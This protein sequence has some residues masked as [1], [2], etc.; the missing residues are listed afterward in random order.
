MSDS[1][2]NQIPIMFAIVVGKT[3]YKGEWPYYITTLIDRNLMPPPE[4]PPRRPRLPEDVRQYSFKLDA[5][6][7]P[8]RTTVD[9]DLM[10]EDT[11]DWLVLDTPPHHA[12]DRELTLQSDKQAT[13]SFTI[14]LLEAKN[15]ATGLDNLRARKSLMRLL[16]N[17][18]HGLDRPPV[19]EESPEVLARRKLQHEVKEIRESNSPKAD[20]IVLSKIRENYTLELG[21]SLGGDWFEHAMM[22]E[23]FWLL[24][25]DRVLELDTE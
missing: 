9:G 6:K 18:L 11:G 24:V 15:G 7:G 17:K 16:R 5:T 22:D 20:M 10:E 13:N 1:K 25:L 12:K 3:M 2:S 21:P 23:K 8:L 14:G 4:V 19:E